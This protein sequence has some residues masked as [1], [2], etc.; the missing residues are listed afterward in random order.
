MVSK[1]ITNKNKKKIFVENK[2]ELFLIYLK[3]MLMGICDLIPGISGGTVAFITGI[4]ERLILAINNITPKNYFKLFSLIINRDKKSFFNL[5][6]KLDIL[7]LILL[8]SGIFSAILIGANLISF[9]LEN[10][11]IFV[12]SFF[13]G[14]ILSSSLIIFKEIKIHSNK[15]IFFGLI[16]F[17]IGISLLFLSPVKVLE[18][19]F[20]YILFGGFMA[21]FA[22]FL[23]GISGSFILLILGLYEYIL[24]IVK[25]KDFLNLIPFAIGAGISFFVVSRFISFIFDKDKCKALYFLFGLVLGTLLIPIRNISLEISI[26]SLNL[27]LELSFLFLLGLII[28]FII[29]KFFLNNKIKKNK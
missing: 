9:L 25:S 22:L 23:P 16:G 26:L 20:L 21:I 29:N 17:L 6:K 13:I 19:S 15:N 11:F 8:F 3:G 27:V 1:N 10:Y 7:F 28:V 5:F 24:E 4:Y 18:P 2:L 12:M 14:L